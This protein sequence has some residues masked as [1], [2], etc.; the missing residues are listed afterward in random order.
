MIKETRLSV[1][2]IDALEQAIR[3]A[4]QERIDTDPYVADCYLRI[5]PDTPQIVH[6]CDIIVTLT[7]VRSRGFFISG[8]L[9]WKDAKDAILLDACGIRLGGHPLWR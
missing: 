9:I 7:F 3:E 8:L 4:V 1:E 6:S 5:V 2:M